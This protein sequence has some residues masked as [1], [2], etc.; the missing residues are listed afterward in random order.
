MISLV[1]TIAIVGVLVYLLETY[2]PMPQPFKIAIRVIVVVLLVLWI[3]RL[4]GLDVP[5]PSPR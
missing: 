4:F 3:V 2:V 1:L 5:L